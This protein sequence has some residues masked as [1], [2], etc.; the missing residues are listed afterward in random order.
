MKKGLFY[1]FLLGLTGC[2]WADPVAKTLKIC[3]NPTG[4]SAKINA[5][6]QIEYSIVGSTIDIAT[7]NWKITTSGG[8]S[9]TLSSTGIN[10]TAPWQGIDAFTVTA[11]VTNLCGTTLPVISTSISPTYSAWSLGGIS[12]DNANNMTTD[13]SGNIYVIG[14]FSSNFNVFDVNRN[15]SSTQTS[16][17]NT[18]VYLAK[19]NAE[20]VFQWVSKIG[21]SGEDNGNEVAVDNRGNVYVTGVFNGS[22]SFSN[23]N[24]N[25]ATTLT[26][27]GGQDVF[28]AKYNANGNLIWA[29][30]GGGSFGDYGYSIA[31][32]NLE[33]VYVTGGYEG[34]IIN[35][36]NAGNQAKTTAG[37][38]T[39]GTDIFTAKFD[40]SGNFLWVRA[41]VSPLAAGATDV[42][43]SI[44]TD[45]AGAS[46]I[47][48][49][50]WG[51]V[52]GS[53]GSNDF[54]VIKYNS[55]GSKVWEKTYGGGGNDVGTKI[56]TDNNGSIYLTGLY[57]A[58]VSSLN[59]AAIGG[60]DAFVLKIRSADGVL[61][62]AKSIGGNAN[63][64]GEGITVD[65][66]G[67]VYCIGRYNS[68]PITQPINLKNAG[69]TDAFVSKYN[70]NGVLIGIESIG[71]AGDDI[72]KCIVVS[73]TGNR[74]FGAG[75]FD[76]SFSIGTNSIGNFG[77][78]DAFIFQLGFR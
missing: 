22:V 47:T 12:N 77:S 10:G 74:I 14:E 23:S 8:L 5:N 42:G 63:E 13:N 25:I 27:I 72:G 9:S 70:R 33:N 78:T 7:I 53:T 26:G 29:T 73:K 6:S 61:D 37:I 64:V 55:D 67:L 48:G 43:Y 51:R 21:G 35:F 34:G 41:E 3:T 38:S 58:T 24:Q 28:L 60:S 11:T 59:L 46:Y 36:F 54:F 32:D 2:E 4:V 57:E 30:K 49:L 18:D 62:W 17:G 40:A 76:A 69:K 45:N 71:G 15:L 75:R 68:S 16:S 31:I 52:S 56:I 66:D 50:S 1:L 65:K 20:G 44:T 39:T 19:Y